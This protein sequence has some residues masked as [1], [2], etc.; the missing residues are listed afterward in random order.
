MANHWWCLTSL[1]WSKC[2]LYSPIC[3]PVS[4]ILIYLSFQSNSSTSLRT[5][6][7]R[8]HIY[9]IF[10][11]EDAPFVETIGKKLQCPPFACRCLQTGLALTEGLNCAQKVLFGLANAKRTVFILSRSFLQNYWPMCEVFVSQLDAITMKTTL[12][13]LR[14]QA[15]QEPEI[16]QSLPSINI[17]D[18]HWWMLLLAK[19]FLP[20]IY[21]F[22]LCFEWK[23]ARAWTNG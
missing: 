3:L 12:I 13:L 11:E 6:Q 22:S 17:A 16:L 23:Y 8:F 21:D 15:V 18:N 20:G 10:D 1:S 4:T 9:F 2:F 7:K 14:T 5:E 19:A